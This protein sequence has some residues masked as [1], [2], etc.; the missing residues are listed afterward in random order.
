[1]GAVAERTE[2]LWLNPAAIAANALKKTENSNEELVAP[3]PS[4]E[5]ISFGF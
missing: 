5:Q 3:E 2:C 4:W 1:M